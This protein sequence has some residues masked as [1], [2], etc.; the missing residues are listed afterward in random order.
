V[1]ARA[2][3]VFL[4]RSRDEREAVEERMVI[5]A[6]DEADARRLAGE[7][8]VDANPTQNSHRWLDAQRSTA[9]EL[10]SRGAT[11]GV[12]ACVALEDD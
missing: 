9:D 2:L 6:R 3:R 1:T 12:V 10:P 8:A 11:P 4:L 7:Y 5:L